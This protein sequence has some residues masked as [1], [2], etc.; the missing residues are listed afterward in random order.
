MR[1]ARARVHRDR[2]L[3][4]L[5]SIKETAERSRTFL[6][7]TYRIKVYCTHTDCV[8]LARRTYT[9]IWLGCLVITHSDRYKRRSARAFDCMRRYH[10]NAVHRHAR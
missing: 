3:P 7:A 4:S 2:H 6:S 5:L 1:L 9:P 8:L 10:E